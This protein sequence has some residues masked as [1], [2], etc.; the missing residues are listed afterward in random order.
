MAVEKILGR[1]GAPYAKAVKANG[2]LFISGNVAVDPNTGNPVEGG[3]KEQTRQVLETLK[4]TVE[5]L[6]SSMENVVKANVFLVDMAD[7][8]GMN[9][10]YKEFF[11]DPPARTTVGNTTLARKEFL[12]EIELIAA[13]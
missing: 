8:G 6:G 12:V 2:F 11:P 10:V 7:F 3:I 13:L 1:P 4:G 5:S 9:E